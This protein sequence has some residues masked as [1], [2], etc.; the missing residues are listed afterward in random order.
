MVEDCLPAAS[1][2]NFLQEESGGIMAN[3]NSVG[4]EKEKRN[5]ERKPDD[6]FVSIKLLNEGECDEEIS[7]VIDRSST[8]TAL[9]AHIPL[10]IGTRIE[11]RAGDNFNAIGEIADWNWDSQTDMVRLGVRLMEKSGNWPQ[12]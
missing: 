6:L 2:A 1:S 8:G 4:A 9:I 3:L 5:E 7:L 10:P 11:I 12:E